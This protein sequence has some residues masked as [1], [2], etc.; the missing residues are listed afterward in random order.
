MF[1]EGIDVMHICVGF[2]KNGDNGATGFF[3]FPFKMGL[4]LLTGVAVLTE[5]G[6]NCVG[7][8]ITPFNADGVDV[9]VIRI[10]FVLSALFVVV[11]TGCRKARL[12]GFITVDKL[13][14]E[15]KLV[16][17]ALLADFAADIITGEA[18]PEIVL[19]SIVDFCNDLLLAIAP[20]T[21]P[22]GP[23][24]MGDVIGGLVMGAE[25]NG[26]LL[27]R[28]ITGDVACP[29][30]DDAADDTTGAFKNCTPPLGNGDAL[31]G[32]GFCG[33]C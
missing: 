32:N 29:E 9:E 27:V 30:Y 12:A 11:G 14:L 8:F 13:V 7:F 21:G 23:A 3:L 26:T 18:F 2:V 28:V 33:C 1:A 15:S 20:A 24:T 25:P 19:D 17:P 5:F 6:F 31:E 16:V 4:A 22:G 10:K